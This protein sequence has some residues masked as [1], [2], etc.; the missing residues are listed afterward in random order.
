MERLRIV[1]QSKN[2]HIINQQSG[3]SSMK[4]A[5][6]IIGGIALAAGMIISGC[7][8]NSIDGGPDSNQ[9]P[10]GVSNEQSAMQYFAATDEFVTNDEKA[11]AD[12]TMA[13]TDYNDAFQKTDAAITPLRWGRFVTSVTRTT[14][15]TVQSGDTMSVVHVSRVIN[16]L[17]KIKTTIGGVD[18]VIMKSFTDTSGRNVVFRRMARD[19]KKYWLNWVPVAASLV[20]GQTTPPPAGNAIRITQIMLIGGGDTLTV[21]DPEATWLRYQWL[22]MFHGGRAD[23]PQFTAGDSLSVSATVMSQSADTDLVVLR[24]GFGSPRFGRT[25]MALVSQSGPDAGG[26]YTKVYVKHIV[27]RMGVGSLNVGVDALTKATLYDDTLPYSA[28]W[29]GIPYRML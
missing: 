28:S 1:C 13:P 23:V 16:G 11:F 14:S 25:P 6:G 9:P 20:S 10:S 17:L 22:K 21:T 15:A 4:K 8:K 29:W 18:T 24:H 26:F 3:R 2:M 5:W 27:P 7:Q 19:A 12:Q